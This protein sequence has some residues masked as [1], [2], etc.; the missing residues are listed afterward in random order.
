MTRFEETR[1]ID[2][3]DDAGKHIVIVEHRKWP[4]FSKADTPVEPIFDYMTEDGQVANKLNGE[5]F[6]LLLTDEVY[7][8]S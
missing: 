1:R 6:L 2:C 3:R 8:A 7:R 5:Q 4:R